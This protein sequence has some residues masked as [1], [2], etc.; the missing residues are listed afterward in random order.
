MFQCIIQIE[1]IIS[2]I[3]SYIQ[4]CSRITNLKERSVVIVTFQHDDN[5]NSILFVVNP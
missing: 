4:H 1:E 5:Q 3:P 2:L